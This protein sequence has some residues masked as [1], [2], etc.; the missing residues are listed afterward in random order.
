MRSLL[1]ISRIPITFSLNLSVVS[2]CSGLIMSVQASAPVKQIRSVSVRDC[3]R[4]D[5]KRLPYILVHRALT[6]ALT[7]KKCMTFIYVNC[8]LNK[9]V[10]DFFLSLAE[11]F[12]RGGWR[13]P[14][15]AQAAGT[16][17]EGRI[18][19]C[20]GSSKISRHHE[21]KNLC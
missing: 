11:E 2:Y 1:S 19:V 13:L 6:V 3:L 5:K 18:H 7:S 20:V 21:C 9:D 8:N 15:V 14:A 16:L 10:I 17:G 12:E 4:I